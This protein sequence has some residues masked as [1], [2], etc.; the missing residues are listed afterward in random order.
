MGSIPLE[1]IVIFKQAQRAID[2]SEGHILEADQNQLVVIALSE[3]T[4]IRPI[5]HRLMILYTR[6]EWA[7]VRVNK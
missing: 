6:N 5:G 2:P 7:S 1:F 3:A 4:R